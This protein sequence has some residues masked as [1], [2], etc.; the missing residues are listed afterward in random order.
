MAPEVR[1]NAI[2]TLEYTNTVDI[3]SLGCLIHVA[4]TKQLPIFDSSGYHD[5]HRSRQTLVKRG[6][7]STAI[8]FIASFMSPR[9]SDRPTAADA[10]AHPWLNTENHGGTPYSPPPT[11]VGFVIDESAANY[12]FWGNLVIQTPGG[13][14]QPSKIL[15]RLLRGIGDYI[16]SSVAQRYFAR[17]GR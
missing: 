15:T 4:I 3:W 6:A 10:L 14:P 2:S 8:E 5:Y 16:V 9:P 17:T 7:S 1:V 11:A 12:E 13:D